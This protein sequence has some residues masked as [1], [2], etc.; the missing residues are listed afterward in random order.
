[1]PGSRHT[2]VGWGAEWIRK[3]DPDTSRLPTVGE[4]HRLQEQGWEKII[5]AKGEREEKKRLG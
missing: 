5:Y 1:M 4:T 3:Q 2:G